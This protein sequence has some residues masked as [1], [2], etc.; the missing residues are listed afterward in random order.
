[1]RIGGPASGSSIQT[2][3]AAKRERKAGSEFAPASGGETARASISS[4]VGALHGVDA[5][6]SIQEVGDATTGK[7]KA[8]QRGHDLLDSLEQM[9]ADLLAGSVPPERLARILDLVRGRLPSGDPRLEGL[10]DEID[11][12]ARVELAKLGHYPE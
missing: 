3:A 2:R 11:L 12:R 6:L 5:L 7:R 1:M 9:R 10:I 4:G 8:M